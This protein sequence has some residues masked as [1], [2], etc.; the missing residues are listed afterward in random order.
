MKT[1]IFEA[2]AA[3]NL[4]IRVANAQSLSDSA[5][6]RQRTGNKYNWLNGGG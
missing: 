1:M 6:S 4:G 3:L 2:F 5:A